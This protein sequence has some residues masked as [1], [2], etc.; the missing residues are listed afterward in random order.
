LQQV[1]NRISSPEV[2]H[3]MIYDRDQVAN[4]AGADSTSDRD[5]LHMRAGKLPRR[6][7]KRCFAFAPQ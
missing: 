1:N 4:E 7:F 6:I 2:E 5:D 3:E